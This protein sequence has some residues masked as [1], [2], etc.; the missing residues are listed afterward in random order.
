MN[1]PGELAPLCA[2]LRPDAGVVTT[3]AAVHLEFFDSVRAIAE[4][5]TAVLRALPPDGLAVLPADCEWFDVLRAAAPG[6]VVTV[7]LDAA[8]DYVGRALPGRPGAFTVTERAGGAAVELATALPGDHVIRDALP[9]I[10]LARGAGAGWDAIRAALGRYAPPPLRWERRTLDG[11]EVINDAYNAGPLSMRAAL[12][13][14]VQTPARGRKWLVLGGM[15]ELGAAAPAEHRALGA[16]VARGDWAG[17]LA[18][19]ELGGLIAD[20]AVRGGWAVGRVTACADCAAAAAELRRRLQP[21]DAVL[22]KA[23]RGE[24]L[25]RVWEHLRAPPAA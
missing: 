17:L 24:Q 10:A 6:R 7:A 20:G 18:V 8:A 16:A 12:A 15:R 5:K 9:A 21:G 23:S 3:V 13:A 1:H 14:F 22:L 25:E 4:E 2:L 11:V 19:G